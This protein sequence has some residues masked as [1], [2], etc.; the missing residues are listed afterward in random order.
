MNGK[1][2]SLFFRSGSFWHRITPVPRS[3]RASSPWRRCRAQAGRQRARRPARG[4]SALVPVYAFHSLP[5]QWTDGSRFFHWIPL[6]SCNS[7]NLV[8]Q[9]QSLEL[10]RWRKRQAAFHGQ[11]QTIRSCPRWNGKRSGKEKE[12]KYLLAKQTTVHQDSSTPSSYLTHK[13]A[14]T[15]DQAVVLETERRRKIGSS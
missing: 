9:C 2:H 7:Y 14:L 6:I 3:W 4:G 13:N 8:R 11:L 5:L 15:G 10:P 1:C 12:L